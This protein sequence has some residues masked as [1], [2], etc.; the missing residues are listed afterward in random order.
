MMADFMF[1][2]DIYF[3]IMDPTKDTP[4]NMATEFPQLGESE[5]KE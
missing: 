1:V 2:D 4:E 3:I 5:W